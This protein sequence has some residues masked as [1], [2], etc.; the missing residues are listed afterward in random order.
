MGKATGRGKELLLAARG[1]T[2]TTTEKGEANA[3]TRRGEV[4]ARRRRACIGGIFFMVK[5]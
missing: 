1:G 5:R 4:S 2:P 3:G